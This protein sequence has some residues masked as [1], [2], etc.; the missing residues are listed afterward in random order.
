LTRPDPSWKHIIFYGVII[1]FLNPVWAVA[2]AVGVAGGV[3][4][5]FAVAFAFLDGYTSSIVFLTFWFLFP[6]INALFDW[7][8]LIISR[9]FLK[10][11][12]QEIHPYFIFQDIVLDLIA[13]LLFMVALVVVLP[14][15]V[16]VVNSIYGLFTEEAQVDWH[17]YARVARSDPWGEGL[18]VTMM[19]V[20]TLIPT[21][22]HVFIG[23]YSMVIN[24]L[25]GK[26]LADY[27]DKTTG[28]FR[29]LVGAMWLLFYGLLVVALVLGLWWSFLS[30][31]G[32]PVADWLYGIADWVYEIP[33]APVVGS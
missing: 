33:P 3:A 29:P 8:S 1:Y 13:G 12:Q 21:L 4:F 17:Y 20:T 15:G 10:E 5:A 23:L 14:F 25:F 9:Y 26:Q 31:S 7:A 32:L 2:V 22:V 28:N 24:L 6:V 30:L 18:M 19:L 16:E 27:L 11:V